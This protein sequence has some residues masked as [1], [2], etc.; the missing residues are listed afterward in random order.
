MLEKQIERLIN[1]MFNLINVYDK[2]VIKEEIEINEVL[3]DGKKI[4]KGEIWGKDFEYGTF[5]FK[6]PHLKK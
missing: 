1:K 3:L 5:S 2:Y 4:N 6:V